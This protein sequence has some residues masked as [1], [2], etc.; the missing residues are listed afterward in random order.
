MK[1]TR[2]G[3]LNVDGS[4]DHEVGEGASAAILKLEDDQVL[5]ARDTI[6]THSSSDAEMHAFTLGLQL[7]E[8]HQVTDLVVYSD[9]DPLIR[10]L[11]GTGKYPRGFEGVETKLA[12]FTSV[13]GVFIE[14]SE[15][16][17]ADLMARSLRVKK[18]RVLNGSRG[19]PAF[20]P[21]KSRGL[22]SRRGNGFR[23]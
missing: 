11:N 2:F 21:V 17:H 10:A 13:A 20:K 6:R 9:F 23:R 3:T 18:P 4:V 1:V 12:A 22:G 5:Y 7:A 14:R 19:I 16:G 8:E 15:N